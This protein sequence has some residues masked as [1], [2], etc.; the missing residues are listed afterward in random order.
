MGFR[1]FVHRLA[2]SLNLKGFVRN[3][4]EGLL[5]EVE[6][7]RDF[8]ERFIESLKTSPPPFAIIESFTINYLPPRGY[9]DFQIKRSAEGDVEILF[10]LPD[11]ATCSLCIE[12]TFSPGERRYLYPFTNCTNC[13]P[14]F[15][16]IRSLPYDREKTSMKKFHMCMECREEYEN[17]E[18]RRYHAQPIACPECGP[19]IW[20]E[21][22]GK[23]IYRNAL[24]KVV[25]LLLSGK[26]VAI[27]G[28]GGFHLACNALDEDAVQRL[29]ERKHRP[30]KPFAVMVKNI[31]T[32]RLF[33]YISPQEEELLSSSQAPIV[34][35]KKKEPFKMAQSV[36]PNNKY[37]GL[38]LPYTPLHH[39]LLRECDIPLIMT[40]GNISDNPICASNEEARKYLA[41]IADAFLLHNRD[42][43]SRCDDSVAI[44]VE[45]EP[46]LIRRSR[47]YSPLPISLPIEGEEILAS[48]GDLKNTFCLVKDRWAFLSQHIGD[49]ET[50]EGLEA[51]GKA[52]KHLS[53]LLNINPKFVAHDLHPA[54]HSSTFARSLGLPTIPIQHHFAHIASCMLDNSV[55]PGNKVLGVAWDG[56]GYGTDGKI[57]GGEIMLVEYGK[58]ER[59]A[60]LLYIPLP[61]NEM[62]VK[63]P[64]RVAISY[65]VEVGEE[66]SLE[67]WRMLPPHFA[68][69]LSRIGREKVD[70][71]KQM[72]KKGFNSPLASS[73]GRLFD[74]VSSLIGVSHMNSYEGQSASELEAIA[75]ECDD[76]YE[77]KLESSDPIIINPIPMIKGVLLDLRKGKSK[78]YIASRFHRSLVEMMVEV[79]KILREKT[80][81]NLVALSGGVFQ[82]SL[83][84]RTALRRLR[85]EG[86]IP[87]SHKKVPTNDG[88]IAIGQAVIASA[89]IKEAKGC[90]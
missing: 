64:W 77:F 45:D 70:V 2:L 27:K 74:A 29:R 39:I 6:G 53:R 63:E 22:D 19:H 11:I 78:E 81:V 80:G 1:P 82:N 15:T 55:P 88:G 69:F 67:D 72:V 83:L 73:I 30:F 13:G 44:V 68:E 25:E 71:V 42:I 54:Y 62:A 40:S 33:A 66:E 57:W 49:L 47:G 41:D 20:L 79:L 18:D 48:G 31:E 14:R 89:L 38:F 56:T 46:R 35:L 65:L 5:I 16:I 52:I 90:A 24:D 37:I 8:L 58:F 34:L 21:I 76:S 7:E 9:H 50:S 36:A 86:F 84:L 26:I 87:L 12:E 4:P 23:R 32:A 59:L 75:D 10:P 28:L 51:Y 43:V 3:T 85:Q 60:H 61:G 17:K